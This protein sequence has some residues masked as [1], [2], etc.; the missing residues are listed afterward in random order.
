MNSYNGHS[1]AQRMKALGWFKKQLAA[2]LKDP[3]PLECECCGQTCGLL[4]W[5]SEDYSD[6]FSLEHIGKHGLCYRCHMIIHCRFKSPE[7]FIQ[8][9]TALFVGKQFAPMMHN[10]WEGFKRDHLVN[11]GKGV[12]Y[13]SIAPRSG[14]LIDQIFWQEMA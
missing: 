14:H 4:M 7:A 12:K 10:N 8:Y 1:P 9:A 11:L 5:H 6:P 13:T 3:R 2:G